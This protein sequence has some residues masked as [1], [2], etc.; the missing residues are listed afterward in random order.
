MYGWMIILAGEQMTEGKNSANMYGWMI[1]LAGEQMT[2]G[3]NSAVV[4]SATTL[5]TEAHIP[6]F[7]TR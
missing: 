5:S 3:K 4:S 6:L 1:I 2:E 7:Q